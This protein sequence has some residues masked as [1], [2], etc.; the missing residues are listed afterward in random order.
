MNYYKN[1]KEVNKDLQVQKLKVDIAEEKINL[2]I[3][4]L[5]DSLKPQAIGKS[6]F[7][8]IIKFISIKKLFDR[9]RGKKR[10]R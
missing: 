2:E 7:T 9:I 8:E 5:K 6:L 1:L 4:K 10:K 3:N